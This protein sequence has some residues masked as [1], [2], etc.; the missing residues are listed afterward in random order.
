MSDW[1][2][3][4][5]IISRMLRTNPITYVLKDD[6]DE[7][8]ETFD[9]EELQKVGSKVMYHIDSILQERSGVGVIKTYLVKW[10]RKLSSFNSWVFTPTS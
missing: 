6:D 2:E 5:F 4:L 10:F 1:T 9:N 8:K 7:L 3:E